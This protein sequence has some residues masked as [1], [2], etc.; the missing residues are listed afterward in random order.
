MKS[1]EIWELGR[2]PRKVIAYSRGAS[3]KRQKVSAQ[4]FARQR[5]VKTPRVGGIQL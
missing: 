3:I 4:Q 1:P 5:T 2:T